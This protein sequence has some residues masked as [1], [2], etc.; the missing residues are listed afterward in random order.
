MEKEDFFDVAYDGVQETVQLKAS[1][2]G[3][4]GQCQAAAPRNSSTRRNSGR[5]N[6]LK[7]AWNSSRES[8]FAF[9]DF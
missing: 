4:V 3:R 5:D 2:A 9:S 1:N 7:H 6:A 8:A